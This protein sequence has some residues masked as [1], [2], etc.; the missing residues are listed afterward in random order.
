MAEWRSSRSARPPAALTMRLAPE[1]AHP[2][3]MVPLIEH[4]IAGIRQGKQMQLIGQSIQMLELFHHHL[5]LLRL[6]IKNA[7]Q[8]A[9]QTVPIA[10][11]SG[12]RSSCAIA[13]CEARSSLS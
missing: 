2:D 4:Q 10:A 8:H 6:G 9:L 5:Q 7:I 12:E 13:T 1:G 3:K 11:V